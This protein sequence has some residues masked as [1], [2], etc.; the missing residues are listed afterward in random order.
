MTAVNAHSVTVSD[1]RV[2]RL[3]LREY[4][5]P[6]I[7]LVAVL[8]VLSVLSLPL[9]AQKFLTIQ[10]QPAKVDVIVVL[11]GDGPARAKLA[12]S[13]WLG[14]FAPGVLISGDGDCYWIKTAMVE[15]GVDEKAIDVECQSGTTWENAL[16]SAPYVKRM[17]ARSGIVVTS[18]YASRRAITSFHAASPDVHWLSVPVTNLQPLWKLAIGTDTYLQKEFPKLIWYTVRGWLGL[19]STFVPAPFPSREVRA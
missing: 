19:N 8:T 15:R 9:L 3:P 18:W 14:K 17:G 1:E 4:L 10:D 6:A 12:A 13:L 7:G 16:Y 2:R 11:G 5:F